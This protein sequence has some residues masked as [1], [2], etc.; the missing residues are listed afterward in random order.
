MVQIGPASW[1]AAVLAGFWVLPPPDAWRLAAKLGPLA[2]DTV[3]SPAPEKKTFSARRRRSVVVC[4]PCPAPP[5]CAPVVPADDSGFGWSTLGICC[6]VAAA[7]G[8]TAVAT[9]RGRAPVVPEPSA[10]DGA[11]EEVVVEEVAV[12]RG[13]VTRRTKL[14]AA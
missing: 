6:S 2:L 8:G 13:P 9:L 3:P 1:I 14:H 4:A 7:C 5:V 12:R 11:L 10:E